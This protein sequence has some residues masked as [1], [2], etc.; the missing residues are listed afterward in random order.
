[1][2]KDIINLEK[3]IINENVF[4]NRMNLGDKNIF[5]ICL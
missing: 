5:G 3:E 1:M 4:K 2:F